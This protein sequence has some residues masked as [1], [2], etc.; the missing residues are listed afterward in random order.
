MTFAELIVKFGTQGTQ[1]LKNDIKT[2]ADGFDNATSKAKGFSD[3]VKSIATGNILSGVIGGLANGVLEFGKSIVQA[4]IDAESANARFAAFGLDAIK[5]RD[6]LGRVAEASTLTSKQLN[7]MTLQLQQSGFN[8]YA[9]VPR[10]AKW[11]DAIGGGNEKLQGMVRLLNLLRSGVKPDQELLQS[12]GFSDIL[13]KAGLKFDQGKLIGGIRPAMEAVMA[14]IDRMTGKIADKMGQTFEARWASVVDVFDKLKETV[15]L[16]LLRMATPWV[17]ALKKTLSALVSSGVWKD[18]WNTFFS[19]G[20]RASNNLIKGITSSGAQDNLAAFIGTILAY[21]E[22]LPAYVEV[23]GNMIVKVFKFVADKLVPLLNAATQSTPEKIVSALKDFVSLTPT[24]LGI[25][26]GFSTARKDKGGLDF[27]GEMNKLETIN[28]NVAA[29]AVAKTLALQKAMKSSG[30]GIVAPQGDALSG[31]ATLGS[32]REESGG[33]GSKHKEAKKA[34][35]KQQK[36]LDLIEK[37]TKVN[38][39]ATLREMTF[40]GGVLGAN[41]VSKVEMSRGISSPSLT[42]ANDI[43]RGFDKMIR[44]YIVANAFNYNIR[45]A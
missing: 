21:F 3:M 30:A 38:A 8:I 22:R 39:E 14:E 40:G 34:Q 23:F 31:T 32:G 13:I 26:M 9:V 19:Y 17:D 33:A 25:Q 42:S 45:R 37:H 36:T 12:L 35:E 44:G 24:A 1:Q 20:I 10:L 18:T 28:K 16:Q 27:S 41:A 5:T 2:V 7:E 6:F 15:G 4:G 11:A 43:V 29:S